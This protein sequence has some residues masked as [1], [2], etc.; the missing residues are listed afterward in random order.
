MKDL[1]GIREIEADKEVKND[2]LLRILIR[3]KKHIDF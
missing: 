1:R 2:L 3:K